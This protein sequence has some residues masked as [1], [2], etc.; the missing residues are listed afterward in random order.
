MRA[1][2][3]AQNRHFDSSIGAV[4]TPGGAAALPFFESAGVSLPEVPAAAATVAEEETVSVCGSPA[5][6]VGAPSL[7]AAAFDDMMEQTRGDERVNHPAVS[8][9]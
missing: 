3:M 4:M 6:D 5:S 7:L 9:I 2:K 1:R 8:T